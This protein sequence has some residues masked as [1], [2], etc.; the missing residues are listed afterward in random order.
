MSTLYEKQ[1]GQWEDR[2]FYSEVGVKKNIP[3]RWEYHKKRFK[4]KLTHPITPKSPYTF[5]IRRGGNMHYDYLR[6]ALLKRGWKEPDDGDDLSRVDIDLHY[7]DNDKTFWKPRNI[8][9]L[10]L[11]DTMRN[12]LNS[13]GKQLFV[14]KSF[15]PTIVGKHMT[16]GITLTAKSRVS[17]ARLSKL[18][19]TL[20]LKPIGGYS[21]YGIYVSQDPSK[22]MTEAKKLFTKGTQ[23]V[24]VS[25]YIENPLLHQ[26]KKFHVR[27]WFVVM[28]AGVRNVKTFMFNQGMIYTASKVYKFSDFTDV[29]IHDSHFSKTDGDYLFPQHFVGDSKTAIRQM[30]EILTDVSKKIHPWISPYEESQYAFET[31]GV[32]FMVDTNQK[33]YLLEINFN[34]VFKTK[35]KKVNAMLSEKYFNSIAC[36]IDPIF[37]SSYRNAP[38]ENHFTPLWGGGKTGGGKNFILM[39]SYLNASYVRN[40]LKK[41]GFVETS[42]GDRPKKVYFT[43]ADLL[44]KYDKRLYYIK[45]E[46]KNDLMIQ[47]QSL[48][49][50]WALYQKITKKYPRQKFLPKTVKWTNYTKLTKNKKYI[51]KP[52][53]GSIGVGIKVIKGK[54]LPNERG[55]LKYIEDFQRE[56][57]REKFPNRSNEVIIS[58]YIPNLMLFSGKIFHIRIYFIPSIINGK[59]AAYLTTFGK[60]ITAASKFS[61][62]NE[63]KTAVFDS[64][65]QHNEK[66][67]WFP[68]D[69]G[70][71]A[72]RENK[73]FTQ[74]VNILNKVASVF[75]D[76]FDNFPEISNGFT[77]LGTDFM[78]DKSCNVHL[79]EINSARTGMKSLSEKFKLEFTKKMFAAIADLFL[80]PREPRTAVKVF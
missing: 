46:Y 66:D 78:I 73:I 76:D 24:T 80:F 7:A 54:D 13:D 70:V 35:T 21:G 38:A 72:M 42:L 36:M 2:D 8:P 69:L 65:L 27:V 3:V 15:L 77:I 57:L 29:N 33:V 11:S 61:K 34:P 71:S 60:I 62:Q 25:Q 47:K 51:I 20:I 32:D 40:E 30:R 16:K 74:M 18:G 53:D 5:I 55:R 50:K 4:S 39:T 26:R 28:W 64:H 1:S 23:S 52:L 14:N 6:A 45:S 31:F 41:K 43:W 68:D 9:Y 17:P 59:F 67:L 44:E 56:M 19:R 12:I 48:T 37:P 49:D 63:Y 79:L 10:S 58:E 22:I 75:K